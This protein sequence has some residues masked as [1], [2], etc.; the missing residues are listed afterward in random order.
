MNDE[1]L[2]ELENVTAQDVQQF[3]PQILAQCQ[4]EVLAHGNLYKEEALK[5][6]DLVERTIKPRRLPAN[7]VPTRRGLIWPSGSNFIYEKQLKDPENVNHCI[8][9]SLYA[10]H[11]YDSVLRAK[12]LLLGQMTDEPCFN[13]LRTIEQLG[14]VVFSGPSFHDI[15][16]GYRILIQ[17]EKDCRYLEGRIENFLNT[18]EQTLNDMS[19]EDFESHKRA[20]INKRLAKLKNLSSEDNRF[21]NHI[22]S[23]SY[24]FL[25]GMP[26]AILRH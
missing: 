13:Q 10:G 8:E 7:Q 26:T 17:S 25:Q 9:Y 21:W 3:F 6:T 2:P 15:W 23:D 18:F 5:I 1:L 20:M 4:I 16:S 12:L 19:D 11:R 24:D 22:Y 14:Y